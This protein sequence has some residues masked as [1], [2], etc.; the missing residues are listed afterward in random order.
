MKILNLQTFNRLVLHNHNT[1]MFKLI[2]LDIGKKHIGIAITDEL[3]SIA[4]PFECYERKYNE[5]AYFSHA[6][7]YF[8]KLI[9]DHKICG[10]IVGFPI[11]DDG[12]AATLCNDIINFIQHLQITEIP[13]TMWNEN[14]S[15]VAAR[16]YSRQFSNRKTVFV[17]NKDSLAASFIL[18]SYLN[19]SYKYDNPL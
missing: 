19:Y 5:D 17:K 9:Q 10:I 14:G 7:T 4:F 13:S 8:S 15:T 2:G 1:R 3:K 18:Q 6:S 12:K 11:M 16:S